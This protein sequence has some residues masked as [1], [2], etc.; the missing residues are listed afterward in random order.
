[1]KLFELDPNNPIDRELAKTAKGASQDGSL[2]PNDI[3]Q[4]DDPNQPGQPG[5]D[6][7]MPDPAMQQ[8]DPSM[9]DDPEMDD[10]PDPAKPID[11]E[12]MSAVQ[13]HSYVSDY[14]H[15]D[16]DS[17]S[18]PV[19]ISQLDMDELSNLRNRIRGKLARTSMEDRVG[20]YSDPDIKAMQDMLGYVDLVMS[21]KK[22]EVK[23]QETKSG[24]RPK[25]RKQPE[26][27]TRPGKKFKAKKS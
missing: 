10:A 1:M 16:P 27:K 25:V 17:A 22:Q 20:M 9:Q 11:S 26:P 8:G 5:M 12:L 19:N 21:Y 2:D 24:N 4:Q 14:D 23:D 7:N 3:R 13:S 18:N 6:P 15:A